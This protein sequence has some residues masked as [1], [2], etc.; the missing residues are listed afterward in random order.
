MS[1]YLYKTYQGQAA[2][3]TLVC[4]AELWELP[5]AVDSLHAA[6][7][8]ESPSFSTEGLGPPPKIVVLKTV[9]RLKGQN[10]AAMR[11]RR[12]HKM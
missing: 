12:E 4:D 10:R 3:V 7:A 11:F 5:A 6:A 1:H 8:G 9:L 2:Q